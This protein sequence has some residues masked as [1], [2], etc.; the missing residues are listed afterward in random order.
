MSISNASLSVQLL[1]A[2]FLATPVASPAAEQQMLSKKELKT[3]IRSANSASDHERIVDYY[4]SEAK[5]LERKRLEHEQ[6][7]AE[8]YKNPARYPGKYPTMGDH[9]RG[10]AAYYQI[11]A[12][13]ANA[14]ADMH[15]RL[16]QG[17]R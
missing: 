17:V 2:I 15:S 4:R 14:K 8:Y 3:L 11:A 5:R 10:L 9:C 13:K 12:Q 7:L 1:L 16:A 6:E